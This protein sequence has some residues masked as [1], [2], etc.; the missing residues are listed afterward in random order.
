MTDLSSPSF[1]IRGRVA[2]VTG[3]YGVL[4]SAIARGLA[5]AGVRVA[6][7]GRRAEAARKE[8]EIIADNGG[9]AMALV[10][11]VLDVDQLRAAGERLIGE[12]GQIDIP[13]N[14]AGGKVARAPS[15]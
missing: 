2:V 15:D 11:D 14:A 7:V 6:V 8:A 1:E 10:A 5:L 3:G 9:E 4:G 12:G 13:V